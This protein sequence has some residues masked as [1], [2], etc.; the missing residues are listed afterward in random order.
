MTGVWPRGAQVRRTSGW[1]IRPVS[2]ISRRLRPLFRAFFYPRP[3]LCSPACNGH[4][5]PLA[6]PALGLLGR[7]ADPT[8]Q[9]PDVPRVIA[10]PKML[11]DHFAHPLQGPQL[12]GVTLAAWP[13]FQQRNQ[14]LTLAAGQ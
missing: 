10:H 7:P 6:G 8:E 12:R 3:V 1:S 11:G 14:A 2:S 9:I 13:T 4:F 5:V